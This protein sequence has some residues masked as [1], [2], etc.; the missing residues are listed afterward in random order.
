MSVE[1]EKAEEDEWERSGQEEQG[2]DWWE[3]GE[4]RMCGLRIASIALI[5]YW[6]KIGR[7]G[8]LGKDDKGR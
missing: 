3:E 1:R 7:R 6:E 2:A 4:V 5:H 8:S